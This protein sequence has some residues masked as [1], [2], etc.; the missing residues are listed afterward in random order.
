MT[1]IVDKMQQFIPGIVDLDDPYPVLYYWSDGSGEV[2]TL[3]MFA[4]GSVARGTDEQRTL[5]AL[6]GQ[7]PGPGWYS[8]SGRPVVAPI[9]D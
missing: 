7:P 1:H 3:T 5:E 9:G 6:I 2:Q 4:D 8:A